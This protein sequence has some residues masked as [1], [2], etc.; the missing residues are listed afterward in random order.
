M[1]KELIGQDECY[2]YMI[3]KL[4]V[5][6]VRRLGYD[7]EEVI[8]INTELI[9]SGN[10]HKFMDVAC[11]V[12]GECIRNFE[13]Q[14]YPVYEPKME[15]MYKYRVFAQADNYRSFNIIVQEFSGF[16]K[17]EMN[18]TFNRHEFLEF[19]CDIKTGILINCSLG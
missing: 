11:Y 3:K 6:F 16:F 15:D 13:L 17:P 9:P 1:T 14:S 19:F 12:D 2:K 18:C 10:N 5:R 8:F 7:C 4:K